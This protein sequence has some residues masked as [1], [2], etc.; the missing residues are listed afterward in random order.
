[1]QR[2]YATTGAEVSRVMNVLSFPHQ[3]TRLVFDADQP[4]E[5]FRGRYEAAV[6]PA[7]PRRRGEPGGRHARWPDVA[8]DQGEPCP[9][10]FVLYWRADMTPRAT[11]AGDPRSCTAYLMGSHAIADRIYREDPAVMLY[12]PL[13]T[14][15]YIDSSD[16]TRFAVEQPSTVLAGFADPA[17]A[18]CG[19]RLDRQLAGLLD[20]LGVGGSRVL[21]AAELADHR[22]G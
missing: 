4:Y 18:E 1:M 19:V 22:S 5:R 9:H 15:I 21:G 16:R 2:R 11:T 13:R 12:V 7:D 6:P 14:L 8:A 20:A 17:I 10:G 3:I